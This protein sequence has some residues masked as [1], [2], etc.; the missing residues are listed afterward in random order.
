[1]CLIA[2]FSENRFLLRKYEGVAMKIGLI[3]DGQ[4]EFDALPLLRSQLE[5]VTGNTIIGPVRADIQP[6]APVGRIARACVDRFPVL[7]VRNVE[8]VIVLFDLESREE[9]PGQLARSVKTAIGNR[10]T[11]PVEIVLK[12][13][14]FENWL[15]ADVAA[16]RASPGRFDFG[17]HCE[18]KIVPNKA[19]HVD[20]YDLICRSI[21]KNQ[22]SKV[23]DSVTIL[24]NADANNIAANSRSFRR[25]L[26]C[27]GHPAYSNQSKQP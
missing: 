24:R 8:L 9:C 16:L 3:V 20:G 13:R 7:K 26:R 18:R 23:R 19:D 14:T 15:V 10:I 6:M 5:S 2:G 12:H 22:Y 27:L 25:F 11:V 1:M 4:S 17:T 21:R